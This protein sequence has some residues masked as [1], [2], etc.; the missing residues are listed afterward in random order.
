M[1]TEHRTVAAKTRPRRS[2]ESVFIQLTS[3]CNLLCS[4]CYAYRNGPP[5]RLSPQQV[6]DVLSTLALQGSSCVT[7][8]SGGEPSLDGNLAEYV[9]LA[10]DYGHRPGIATNGVLLPDGVLESIVECKAF[11]QFSL[12]TLDPPTFKRICGVDRLDA[13][14]DNIERV[15]N[16]GIEP[17]LSATTTTENFKDLVPIV[18]FALSKGITQLHVGK[19]VN[20]GRASCYR[21]PHGVRLRDLWDV[22]YPIQL[23]NYE[24]IGI[25]LVEEFVLPF[26]TGAEKRIYCASM[27]GKGLEITSS[28]RVAACGMMPDGPFT[29]GNLNKTGFADILK[30]MELSGDCFDFSR[31][32]HC[33]TCEAR[34]ICGCGCRAVAFMN[35]GDP[36]GTYPYCN[37][38]AEILTEIRGDAASGRLDPYFRFLRRLPSEKALNS[39]HF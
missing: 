12:D 10:H 30:G 11:V 4:Y 5:G 38:I 32:L 3:S 21:G 6:N 25:D 28:G 9:R 33:K 20:S 1:A 37:D 26:A 15:L 35:S 2:I 19:L 13:V 16:A 8:F 36:Y 27:E 29:Y 24:R 17:T 7:I 22:L 23:E 18:A 14:L 39:R 34:P 31:T